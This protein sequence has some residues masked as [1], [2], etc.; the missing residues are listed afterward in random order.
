MLPP[1]LE[2]IDRL[3]HDAKAGIPTQIF[4]ALEATMQAFGYN[5]QEVLEY[6]KRFADE[7]NHAACDAFN[8][9]Q[10][11]GSFD[12]TNVLDNQNVADCFDGIY[13]KRL[14][15]LLDAIVLEKAKENSTEVQGDVLHD[16]H[17][18]AAHLGEG[19]Q[20]SEDAKGNKEVSVYGSGSYRSDSSVVSEASDVGGSLY[21]EALQDQGNRNG[22]A[23]AQGSR[24]SSV[25]L[26]KEEGA[27]NPSLQGAHASSPVP[28]P[29]ASI[30]PDNFDLSFE[31]DED[32]D[33]EDVDNGY[34]SVKAIGDVDDDRTK[35]LEGQDDDTVKSPL[36]PYHMQIK[37][38]QEKKGVGAD[39]LPS[40][41]PTRELV[42]LIADNLDHD[43]FAVFAQSDSGGQWIIQLPEAGKDR[44]AVWSA[45]RNGVKCKDFLKANFIHNPK[46]TRS[47]S[48]GS[49][50]VFTY[51]GSDLKDVYRTL[52][53]LLHKYRISADLIEGYQVN[54]NLYTN[55][56]WLAQIANASF[57][58]GR[59]LNAQPTTQY[60]TRLRNDLSRIDA[61]CFPLVTIDVQAESLDPTTQP[62]RID[63]TAPE[64]LIDAIAQLAKH[65]A[66]NEHPG[67]AHLKISA[68]VLVAAV[69]GAAVAALIIGAIGVMVAAF[70]G[71]ASVL[72]SLVSMYQGVYSTWAAGI[73]ISAAAAGVVTGGFATSRYSHFYK[74]PEPSVRAS[75]QSDIASMAQDE[76]NVDRTGGALVGTQ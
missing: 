75:L 65:A 30:N 49:I 19:S 48:T 46:T 20:G 6:T 45:I 40:Q 39:S 12:F 33:N 64:V 13:A 43:K 29:D 47:D 9:A 50:R 71:P 35:H 28:D 51:D 59:Q 37:D 15:L 52:Y 67:W 32:V 38:G 66:H 36:L 8:S 5:E 61:I 58:L 63:S 76:T 56:L 53:Q 14:H 60:F 26:T 41:L 11:G 25:A 44:D 16:T 55:H 31:D 18:E 73:A 24:R 72:A 22:S 23:S 68:H 69:A 4:S 1:N 17:S 62:M 3:V 54:S 2:S 7:A 21:E 27:L 42:T 74:A 34:G 57:H 10:T 70:A